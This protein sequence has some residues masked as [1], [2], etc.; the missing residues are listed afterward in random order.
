MRWNEFHQGPPRSLQRSLTNLHSILRQ[1]D[2]RL[3]FALTLPCHFFSSFSSLSSFWYILIYSDKRQGIRVQS[4]DVRRRVQLRL[5]S[6]R[7]L[8]W[9]FDSKG[10][11]ESLDDFDSI[12]F[13]AEVY[14]CRGGTFY[15][16]GNRWNNAN[17]ASRRQCVRLPKC[18]MEKAQRQRAS[19][20]RHDMAYRARAAQRAAE[21]LKPLCFCEG[22][23]GD[24][25]LLGW[26]LRQTGSRVCSQRPNPRSRLHWLCAAW[27]NAWRYRP[28]PGRAEDSWR[29]LKTA[30]DSWWVFLMFHVDGLNV[31]SCARAF[32]GP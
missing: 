27:R 13:V 11:Y 31:P 5:W 22:Q 30:E 16:V 18:T 1:P 20:T 24:Y 21:W 14:D 25:G 3:L 9:V 6:I 17:T 4:V 32:P 10:D 28:R 2:V 23:D 29:Q 26:Q 8:I 12:G 19:W 15:A 7:V